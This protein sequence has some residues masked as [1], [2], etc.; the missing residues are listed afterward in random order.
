VTASTSPVVRIE[1][2]DAPPRR[3][4]LSASLRAAT[5]ALTETLFATDDG[6]AP[7]DR[8]DWLCDDLD[9]FMA[10][11]GPRAASLYRLCVFAVTW[12]AP[13]HVRRVGPFHRL[14]FA[15]RAEA[16]ERMERGPLG[17]AVFGAKAVLCF[18]WYEHPDNARMTGYDARCLGGAR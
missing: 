15:A 2:P 9:D 18:I 5:S 8:V 13:L 7:A 12:L 1:V 10:R 14:D 17:M 16:L 11:S 4:G 6:P 3:K